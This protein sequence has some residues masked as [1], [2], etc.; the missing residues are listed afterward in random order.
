MQVLAVRSPADAEPNVEATG[1]GVDAETIGYA[2]KRGID[3]PGTTAK[4]TIGHGTGI[5]EIL[6]VKSL[7]TTR[8]EAV[9]APLPDITQHVVE[10]EGILPACTDRLGHASVVQDDLGVR[11]PVIQF[12]PKRLGVNPVVPGVIRE[13]S[14]IGQPLR[15]ITEPISRVGPTSCRIFPLR[16]RRKTIAG[17]VAVCD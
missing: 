3:V 6:V 13:P 12:L 10:L 17:A 15:L 1:S 9:P 14:V 11:I 5:H 4:Y 8:L 7:V 16:L 2:Q